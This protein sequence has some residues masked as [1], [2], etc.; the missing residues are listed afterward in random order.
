MP[1]TGRIQRTEQQTHNES[2]AHLNK[3]LAFRINN[4]TARRSPSL[5][6]IPELTKQKQ[7]K[8]NRT[9]KLA[10]QFHVAT[11]RLT[12][13]VV[14]NLSAASGVAYTRLGA[15]PTFLAAPN[16]APKKYSQSAH[17]S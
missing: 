12:A 10:I 4:I 5:P 17:N 14:K 15:I 6:L 7:R 13:K 2:L 8:I 3:R 1:G 9:I 16:P 11:L